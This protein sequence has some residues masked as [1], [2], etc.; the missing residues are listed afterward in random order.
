MSGNPLRLR[1]LF[2]KYA[3]NACSPAELQEFWMLMREYADNDLLDE[4][5]KAWWDKEAEG[6]DPADLVDHQK[7]FEQIIEKEK[8]YHFSYKRWKASKVRPMLRWAAAAAILLLISNAGYFLFLHKTTKTEEIA[9]NPVSHDVAAPQTNCAVITLS[10]GQKIFLDSARN[11]MLAQQGKIKIVKLQNGEIAYNSVSERSGDKNPEYNT[12]N[13]PRGSKVINITLADGSRVWLNAG[14]SLTYPV[15]FTGNSREVSIT[16]EAYF[17]VV[18]NSKVPFKVKVRDELVEDIGTSFNIKAYSD[19]PAMKTTLVEGAVKITLLS[20]KAQNQKDNQAIFLKPGEQLAITEGSTL[21][22]QIN[23]M[24]DIDIQDVTAWKDGEFRFN[25]VDV[26]AIMR[27]A[28]RWYNVDVVYDGRI[29]GTISGG[30]SR[31][32]NISQLLHILE[33]TGKMSFTIENKKIIV[34]PVNQK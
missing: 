8:A 10:N 15:A 18:H 14:S 2:E 16:G 29:N 25:S 30:I 11:G 19:E 9:R 13:N 12:L 5:M 33:M 27:E 26:A 24:K 7:L 34:Q 1:Y 28:A 23:I 6:R 3:L 4:D 21:Q 32:V 31:S 20:G 22:Q 17:E